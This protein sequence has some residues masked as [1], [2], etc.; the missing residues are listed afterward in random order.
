MNVAEAVGLDF[1]WAEW[2]P[3]HLQILDG[4]IGR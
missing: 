2:I 3:D 1:E 4:R